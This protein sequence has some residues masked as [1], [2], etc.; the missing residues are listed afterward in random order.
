MALDRECKDMPYLVGRLIAITEHYAGKHFGPGT[1]T[2]MYQHPAHGLG[3]FRK[4]VD[5]NDEYLRE[6]MATGI[7]IPVTAKNEIEKGQMA[8]GYYHQKTLYDKKDPNERLR[9]GRRIAEL[10]REY[11]WPDNTE[12][13]PHIGMTQAQLAEH[14][15]LQQAHIARIETGRYSV[16]LDTLTQIAEALG[17]RI[18]FVTNK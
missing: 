8:I 10:R 15:G 7:E 13:Q 5:D 18:D 14:C 9:I 17:T 4:Y 16:G 1:V 3:V 12:E 11:V 6:I 2:S